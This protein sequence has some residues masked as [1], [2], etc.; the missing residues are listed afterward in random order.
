VSFTVCQQESKLAVFSE[1][2]RALD[3]IASNVQ[4]KDTV[5]DKAKGL[6]DYLFIDIID[7]VSYSISSLIK[8]I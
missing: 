6:D 3:D 7:T 8:I 4:S 5:E 1:M 2:H